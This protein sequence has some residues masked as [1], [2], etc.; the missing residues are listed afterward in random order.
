[1]DHS[2]ARAQPRSLRPTSILRRF[3]GYI[4]LTRQRRHL[5]ALDAHVLHDIGVTR[6]EAV[7][8]ANRPGWDVPDHWKT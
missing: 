2:I 4:A 7:T 5:R 6:D 3:A 8:E 1:M